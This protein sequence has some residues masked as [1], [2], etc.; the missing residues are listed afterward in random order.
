[1]IQ[2]NIA[3]LKAAREA[4]NN[5]CLALTVDEQSHHLLVVFPT[6]IQGL[7]GLRVEYPDGNK[8]EAYKRAYN[9]LEEFWN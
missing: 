4:V 9:K 1:M 6:P 8:S 7:D 2:H 3:S 5:H